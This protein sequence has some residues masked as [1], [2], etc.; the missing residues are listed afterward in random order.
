VRATPQNVTVVINAST[1]DL[2]V[3]SASGEETAIPRRALSFELFDDTPHLLV[4]LAGVGRLEL[5][6][7][8]EARELLRG[9]LPLSGTVSVWMEK[10]GHRSLVAMGVALVVIT[11]FVI[12]VPPRIVP[13]LRPF[14]T[15]RIQSIIADQSLVVL[16]KVILEPSQIEANKK[17]E[18]AEDA[19]R[20]QE[21]FFPERP[22]NILFRQIRERPSLMNAAAL[23]PNNMVIIDATVTGL[24]PDELR[25][26]VLHE[27]GHLKHHHGVDALIRSSFLGLTSLLILGGDP[28]TLHGIAVSLFHA[29]YSQANE[30]EADRFAAESLNSMGLDPMLL[31]TALD[32]IEQSAE[33]SPSDEDKDVSDYFASHPRTSERKEALRAFQGSH[34]RS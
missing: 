22:M 27:I 17:R 18:V 5:A 7:T 33:V 1:G 30:M 2:T 8:L 12:F 16:D 31:A 28:G 13:L 9:H 3:R 25:A 29:Q 23:I 11:L 26:V 4:S 20:L 21:R 32:K 6:N 14:V 34:P 19:K 24:S 15:E 10:R